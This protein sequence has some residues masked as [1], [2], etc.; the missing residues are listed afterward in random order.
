MLSQALA[1]QNR[2][3]E[4]T[5][6]PGTR[7]FLKVLVWS[8]SVWT[9]TPEMSCPSAGSEWLMHLL[10]G[11][12]PSSHGPERSL[13]VKPMTLFCGQDSFPFC[14]FSFNGQFCSLCLVG[15]SYHK[16]IQG[17]RVRNLLLLMPP[18][19]HCGRIAFG[20]RACARIADL[21]R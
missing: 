15:S 17:V 2:E 8:S 1:A 11:Y 3:I 6:T 16:P 9:W 21:Y 5:I 13:F 20:F 14:H 4:V 10:S 7:N 18:S 12:Y 19:V